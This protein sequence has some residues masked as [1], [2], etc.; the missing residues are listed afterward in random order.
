VRRKIGDIQTEMCGK[1]ARKM[2]NFG[3]WKMANL[4]LSI[5]N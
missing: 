2:A 3:K 4:K 5:S 1:A